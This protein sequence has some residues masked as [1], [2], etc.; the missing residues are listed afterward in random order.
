MRREV[1][2]NRVENNYKYLKKKTKRFSDLVNN[3][4]GKGFLGIIH[5]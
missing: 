2:C 4:G 3:L 1:K 5:Q